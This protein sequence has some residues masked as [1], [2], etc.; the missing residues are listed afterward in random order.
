MRLIFITDTLNSGGA[1]RVVSILA[2]HFADKQQ[3]EIICL[4]KM[5]VFY[6]IKPK[7]NVLFADDY[8]KNW[9][10]KL[11]WLRKHVTKDDVLLP[12]MIRVYC[13]TLLALLGKKV[14]IIASER[15]DPK[16]AKQPWK[17]FRS[18]LLPKVKVLV[19]QTLNIK[20]FFPPKIQNRTVIILNPLDLKNCYQ[21]EWNMRSKK[22]IAVGRTD[23]QKNYPMMIRAF[24]QLH[25]TYPDYRLE[26]W[27]NRSDEKGAILV[28]LIDKLGAS[29]FISVH[30]RTDNMASLY[31]EAY[32]FVMSSNYEGLSNALI[33]ALCSGLPVVATKV[34]G[35]IDLIENGKNGLLVD[36]GDEE[37]FLQ[38]MALLLEKPVMAKDLAEKA[39]Q[40]RSM[41]AKDKICSQ[42]DA[43]I[44]SIYKCSK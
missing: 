18:L 44:K 33:E 32:M 23:S 8:A 6:R 9:L 43:L 31:G 35:A 20:K 21:G 30:G 14:R 27:G 36:I 38:A 17:T 16:A 5:D 10:K 12:F 34:S 3:T 25:I 22:I 40:C 19:V 37:G 4:R 29:D 2:N 41:F 15:N 26:I 24:T 39:R 11:Y 28:S 1:E 13:V 42:W 7:V